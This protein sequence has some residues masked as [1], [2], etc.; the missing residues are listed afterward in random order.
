MIDCPKCG[1]R[2]IIGPKYE[3]ASSDT[4]GK[5][6]LRYACFEC[7]YSMTT[8]TRDAQQKKAVER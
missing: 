4:V 5:E 7:G 3:P 2:R 1:S 6:R 8:P